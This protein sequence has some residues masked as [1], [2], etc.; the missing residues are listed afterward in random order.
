MTQAISEALSASPF[1]VHRAVLSALIEPFG[2]PRHRNQWSSVVISD[3][4][5][6]Y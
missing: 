2:R 1:T 3:T 4:Q 6:T 5:R